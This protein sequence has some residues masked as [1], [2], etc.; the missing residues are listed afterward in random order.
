MAIG[1]AADAAG[2]DILAG[3]E[4]LRDTYI[5]HNRTRDYL[6]NHQT[7]GTHDAAAINAGVLALARIPVMDLAHIPV[8]DLSRIPVIDQSRLPAVFTAPKA[9]GTDRVHAVA[10]GPGPYYAAWVD[11]DHN[12]FRNTSS[13]RYK[14][15]I[16]DHDA[17]DAVLALRPVK[18]DRRGQHTPNDEVGFIAEEVAEHL[19]EAVFEFE[20]R[21]DGIYDRPIIAALVSLVQRQQAQIDEL[22]DLVKGA[23]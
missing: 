15:N 16:R 13:R 3:T 17:A 10:S 19:P 18:F 23:R 9:D 12:F 22:R 4:D 11:A 20:G 2:M 6:A 1:D 7:S 8:L 14:Q 5:E 21:I